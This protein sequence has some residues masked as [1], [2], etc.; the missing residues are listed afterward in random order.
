MARTPCIVRFTHPM[1]GQTYRAVQTFDG[2]SISFELLRL[3][4]QYESEWLPRK[5]AFEAD[6]SDDNAAFYHEQT[7]RQL[8]EFVEMMDYMRELRSI[9]D[10]GNRQ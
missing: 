5:L 8:Q 6:P 2:K 9:F 7:D 4:N 10:V 1:T 3:A